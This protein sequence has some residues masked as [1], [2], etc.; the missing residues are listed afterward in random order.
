MTVDEFL[1]NYY[2]RPQIAHLR[3]GQA[4]M[5]MLFDVKPEMYKY[6]TNTVHDCFYQDAKIDDCLKFIKQNWDDFN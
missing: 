5:N 3:A 1:Y 4:L 6:I 2:H